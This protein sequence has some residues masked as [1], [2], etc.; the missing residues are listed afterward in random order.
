MIEQPNTQ[1]QTPRPGQLILPEHPGEGEY[2][3]GGRRP[4]V[5]PSQYTYLGATST[6]TNIADPFQ[7]LGRSWHKDAAHKI[8]MIA[9]AAV[10]LSGILFMALSTASLLQGFGFFSQNI[11][12]PQNPS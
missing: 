10:V 4:P 5:G 2:V 8:L 7:K 12:I 11:T 6:F 9:V 3:N 1:K